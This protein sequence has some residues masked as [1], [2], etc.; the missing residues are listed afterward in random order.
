MKN[1]KFLMVLLVAILLF[2]LVVSAEGE[3]ATDDSKEATVYFF[4]GEGCSHCAEAEEWFQ[5]IEEEYGSMFK[6]VDYETWYNEDNAKLMEDVAA[7]RGEEASGVPYIIV[8]DKSWNG[9]AQDYADEILSQI[10]SVY[11]QDPADRYDVLSYVDA[12][13][14]TAGNGK[15][16]TTSSK[17]KEK[18]SNSDSNDA[19]ALIIILLVT[20]GIGFGIYKA[21]ENT[22]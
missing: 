8:G 6:I 1:L 15:S 4:R 12:S 10:K 20:G 9:F 14:G 3:E 19:L 5:S 7:A 2:P 22:K 16:S 21:R 18:D 13:K 11:E 17:S